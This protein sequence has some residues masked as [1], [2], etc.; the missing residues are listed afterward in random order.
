VAGRA[1]AARTLVATQHMTDKQPGSHCRSG[2]T[3]RGAPGDGGI[4]DGRSDDG[5]P[6]SGAEHAGGILC[7]YFGWKLYRDGIAS[8]VESEMQHGDQWKFTLKALGPG[9]FFAAFGM[10]ILVTVVNKQTVYEPVG[11][12]AA[13]DDADAPADAPQAASV[14][15]V[16]PEGARSEAAEPA[17]KV[18]LWFDPIPRAY[19]ATPRQ[20]RLCV[21]YGRLTAY[22]GDT[23]TNEDFQ[24]AIDEAVAV[25]R[26]G[27]FD[28]ADKPKVNHAI[29][30]LARLSSTG[31]SVE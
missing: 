29:A 22:D 25:M 4:C 31:R 28:Q 11:V 7:I 5:L 3:Q 21:H 20:S 19:A 30:I 14:A 15:K 17:P 27:R 9:V 6:V 23:I 1:L 13:S 12:E 24:T 16:A 26:S 18:S 8:A 10:W 2:V